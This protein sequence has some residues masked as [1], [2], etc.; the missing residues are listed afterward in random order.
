MSDMPRISL[1]EIWSELSTWLD[2]L[3]GIGLMV[4][5]LGFVV[6]YL[7]PELS[8]LKGLPNHEALAYV[9]GAYW[10]LRNSRAGK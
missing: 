8:F 2:R 10:L 3:V 7:V 5:V 4:V 1:G 9:A 6:R